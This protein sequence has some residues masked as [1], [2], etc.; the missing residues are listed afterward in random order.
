MARKNLKSMAIKNNPMSL[1]LSN[2]PLGYQAL[3]AGS[4]LSGMNP[5][6]LGSS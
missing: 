5:L 6:S 4:K 1:G 3:G 2:Q